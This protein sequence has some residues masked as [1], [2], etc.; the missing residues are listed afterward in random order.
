MGKFETHT[1]II[2]KEAVKK[3]KSDSEKMFGN[4]MRIY[5]GLRD[6]YI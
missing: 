6:I 4:T 3:K 5:C 1:W 2:V